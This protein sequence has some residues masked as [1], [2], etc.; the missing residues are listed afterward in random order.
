MENVPPVISI[1][2]TAL[3][4][5]FLLLFSGGVASRQRRVPTFQASAAATAYTRHSSSQALGAQQSNSMSSFKS[6]KGAC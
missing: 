4:P 1:A 3:C 5:H 2:L 6:S